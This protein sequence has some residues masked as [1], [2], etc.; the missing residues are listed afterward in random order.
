MQSILIDTSLWID[1]FRSKDSTVIGALESG[2]CVIH[3]CVLGE[4][5]LGSIPKRDST[6]QSLMMLPRLQNVSFQELLI[7]IKNHHLWNTGIGWNDLHI[8]ASCL[9]SKSLL[10]TKD[11]ALNRAWEKVR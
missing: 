2:V 9:V 6:L 5:S 10:K 7:L 8:L 1:H 4:L 11:R 3:E